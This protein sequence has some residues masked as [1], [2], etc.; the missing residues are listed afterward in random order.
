MLHDG[1]FRLRARPTW[2]LVTP[3][4]AF[5]LAVQPLTGLLR[6]N[7][8]LVACFQAPAESS[9]TSG[10]SQARPGKAAALAVKHYRNRCGVSSNVGG[11]L[12]AAA[13]AP[14]EKGEV[15]EVSNWFDE[16]QPPQ[17]QQKW[18]DDGEH[19]T[20]S[21]QDSGDVAEIAGQRRW[22]RARSWIV[23]RAM[24]R[25]SRRDR[26]GLYQEG[27]STLTPVATATTV[28]AVE[29]V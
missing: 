5:L 2:R 7:S 1:R 17:Q 16:S 19:M 29:Q 24:G 27:D 9:T 3:A 15:E 20:Q 18:D 25:V 6:N 11:A 4:V 12:F 10:S 28:T 13:V 22:Q 8:S 14:E 23:A 26:A 21:P